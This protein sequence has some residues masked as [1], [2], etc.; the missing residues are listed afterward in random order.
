MVLSFNAIFMIQAYAQ[1]TTIPVPADEGAVVIESYTALIVAIGTMVGTI[2]SIIGVIA[3]FIRNTQ[4]KALAQ[5]VGLGMETFGQKTIEN[6]D[7]IRKLAKAGYE[8]SPEEGKKFLKDHK[9]D[10][11]HLTESVKKGVE[12]LEVIKDNIPGDTTKK[13]ASWKKTLPTETFDTKPIAE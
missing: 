12:Q 11:E 9:V 13:I 10:A 3:V 1:N 5:Q 8:L 7:R 4:T 2:G 6:T